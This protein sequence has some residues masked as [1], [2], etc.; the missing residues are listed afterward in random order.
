MLMHDK[1]D[2]LSV[3]HEVRLRTQSC[4]I[5]KFYSINSL[6]IAATVVCRPDRSLQK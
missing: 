1:H 4:N 2:F 6:K 3:R 5:V